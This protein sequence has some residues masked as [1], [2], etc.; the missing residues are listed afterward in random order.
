MAFSNELCMPCLR[1]QINTV[2]TWKFRIH[3]MAL[4]GN[5]ADGHD[6]QFLQFLKLRCLNQAGASMREENLR[7]DIPALCCTTEGEE[8]GKVLIRPNKNAKFLL[9]FAISR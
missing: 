6:C 1:C 5:F 8:L 3:T 4:K 9:H 7:L 2:K